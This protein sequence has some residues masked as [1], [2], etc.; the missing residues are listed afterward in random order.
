ML[1][2]LCA[3]WIICRVAAYE[4]ILRSADFE[5]YIKEFGLNDFEPPSHKSPDIPNSKAWDY[6]RDNMPLIDVPDKDLERT[7]YFRL[8]TYRKHIKLV[9]VYP[10]IPLLIDKEKRLTMEQ[11]TVGVNF[12]IVTEFL[13]HVDW[14]GYGGSISCAAAHHFREG[15]WLHDTKFLESYAKFWFTDNAGQPRQYS[16]WAAD[17]IKAFADVT[18]DK[19]MLLSMLPALI[20]NYETY[21]KTNF[22]AKKGLWFNVDNRDGMEASISGRGGNFRCYRPTLNSYQ[23]GDAQAIHDIASGYSHLGAVADKYRAIAEDLRNRVNLE[24]YD[25][26]ASFYKVLP[27]ESERN[28][29]EQQNLSDVR[30]LHGYTPW[31]FSLPPG[32]DGRGE[33]WRQLMDRQGFFSAYGPTTAEHRHK[34]FT[35]EYSKK[36]ECQWNGPV[37][38]YATSI[39][40]TALANYLN[41]DKYK[42]ENSRNRYVSKEDYFTLLKLYA[43]SQR[44]RLEAVNKTVDWIDENID[45]SSGVWLSRAMLREWRDG[46]WA[47]SKGGEERGKDYNHSTFIDLLLSGLFGIRPSSK[48]ELIVNPLVSE[49]MWHHFCVDN[50]QYH[51]RVI[52][53]LY[54]KD[55]SFY[56]RGSGF[57]VFVDG[58]L[59]ASSRGL[60]RLTIDLSVNGQ[61][62]RRATNE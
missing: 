16:F 52:T 28:P 6:L 58:A 11:K 23:F 49:K 2:L 31:Y 12:Q 36:H 26:N 51:K 33:A 29:L 44:R 56:N 14:E 5:H 55:G 47:Q 20:K 39:T 37:W 54:D 3:A 22:N 41:D 4:Y 30:E 8:W 27:K 61:M 1:R 62:N 34:G 18:G 38:P 15:R 45:P 40:L 43:L 17:S 60:E 24:L 32:G 25:R 46:T 21:M 13:N 53:L 35:V 59:A 50:I 7:Y 42:E 48:D 57:K 9:T 19:E 10:T